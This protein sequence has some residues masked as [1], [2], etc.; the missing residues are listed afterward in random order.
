M[1]TPAHVQTLSICE[2]TCDLQ[3]FNPVSSSRLSVT[4]VCGPNVTRATHLACRYQ[5][6]AGKAAATIHS[7]LLDSA[8]GRLTPE[9]ALSQTTEALRSV[10]LS[11]RKASYL[12][13]L[14]AN[15]A[16]GALGDR[17]ELNALED[18]DLHDRLTAVKG[19]SCLS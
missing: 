11:E 14:A 7:R 17:D 1:R 6:L 3:F 10:G 5:Q 15:F 13:D 18:D 4:R 9:W 16:S 12:Q 8:A 19:V 2:R